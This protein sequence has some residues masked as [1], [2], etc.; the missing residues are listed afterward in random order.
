MSL[1]SGSVDMYV[2]LANKKADKL[3]GEIVD[4]DRFVQYV[5]SSFFSTAEHSYA[6]LAKTVFEGDY[7]KTLDA[8]IEKLVESNDWIK[9]PKLEVKDLKFDFIE[10]QPTK[11][12]KDI[13]N[14]ILKKM[15]STGNTI[16]ALCDKLNLSKLGIEQSTIDQIPEFFKTGIDY[17]WN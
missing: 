7:P 14:G 15:V 17:E 9:D 8:Y 2:G 6:E 16:A 13:I 3:S 10:I 5:V 11:D 1:Y 4:L 12:S